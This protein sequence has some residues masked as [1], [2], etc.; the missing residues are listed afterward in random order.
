MKFGHFWLT[1]SRRSS[2]FFSPSSIQLPQNTKLKGAADLNCRYCYNSC[3]AR[4]LFF[5]FPSLKFL[6]VSS[7]QKILYRLSLFMHEVKTSIMRYV[8]Q[9]KLY[10]FDFCAFSSFYS[11]ILNLLQYQMNAFMFLKGTSTIVIPERYNTRSITKEKEFFSLEFFASISTNIS[12]LF[13]S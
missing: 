7:Q 9:I 8:K 12:K 5:F 1:F 4:R 13:L 11:G 6:F 2:E 3:K 10:R